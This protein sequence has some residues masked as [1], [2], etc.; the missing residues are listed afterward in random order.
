ML[1]DAHNNC[2]DGEIEYSS[3]LEQAMFLLV[4]RTAKSRDC[5]RLR[6]EL[7]VKIISDG[8]GYVRLILVLLPPPLTF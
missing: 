6:G 5:T 8:V 2:G 1:I 7:R 3:L 4:P